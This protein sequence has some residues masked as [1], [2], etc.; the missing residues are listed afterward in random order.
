MK[1]VSYIK[2][3]ILFMII[4]FLNIIFMLFSLKMF[5]V[6]K[7]LIIILLFTNILTV[8]IV[9]LYEYERKKNFYNELKFNIELLEKKYLV[10]ETIRKP[11]TYE[12][13]T[14]Y[15]FM[16][17]INKSMID[18]IKENKKNIEEFKEYVEVWIHEVK[19]PI[20]SLVLK[21]HNYPDKFDS[22]FV[23]VIKQL[24]DYIDDILYYVRS[25]DAANDFLIQKVQISELI[26]EVIL[27]NKNSLMDN[28]IAINVEGESSEVKTDKKWMEY[29]LNQIINNAI[30][31]KKDTDSWITIKTF[32][33]KE[34]TIIS[35]KDNGIGISSSDINSV[36]KKSFT[37]KNG[38]ERVKST[39]M[40]L[41]IAKKLC[42][43]L[44][45]KVEIESIED[46][47][48]KVSIK[49]GKDTFLIEE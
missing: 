12:E 32:E 34:K 21:A 42:D 1:F 26:R 11:S 36:F 15:E 48:T 7:E 27:K 4:F 24:D 23:R 31:Y 13:K 35:V 22:E 17:E 47:Y 10:L 2:D 25:G 28:D 40:G 20:A 37:G 30:K 29:I 6:K 44:G 49:F 38:R 8:I 3:K 18:H 9:F 14:I 43:K 39:G 33:E 41:Y 46:E 5:D 45:H 19:I 16:R